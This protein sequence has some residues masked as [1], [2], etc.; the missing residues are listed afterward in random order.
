MLQRTVK[1]LVAIV[2]ALVLWRGASLVLHQSLTPGDLLIFMNYLKSAFEPPMLKLSNQMA[3]IAKATSSA[4]RVVDI[5]DYEP[6]VC[7]LP[8]A[9]PAPPFSG[10][11]VL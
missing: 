2:M 7:D 6:N 4:E 9:K 1:V 5:L 3:Q 8:D 11:C 10:S